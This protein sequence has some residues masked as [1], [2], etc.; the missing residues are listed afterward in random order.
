MKI[1]IGLIQTIGIKLGDRRRRIHI[2][3]GPDRTVYSGRRDAD[4]AARI[5]SVKSTLAVEIKGVSSQAPNLKA[6]AQQC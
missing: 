6:N 2:R 3:S 1:R 4:E 5:V